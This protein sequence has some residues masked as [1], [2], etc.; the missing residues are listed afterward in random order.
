MGLQKSR[1]RHQ[2]EEKLKSK[3]YA[4]MEVGRGQEE[5]KQEEVG[6]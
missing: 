6:E 3:A 2:R 1:G 4:R 5:L